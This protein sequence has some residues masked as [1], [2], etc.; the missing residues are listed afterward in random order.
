M[1]TTSSYFVMVGTKDNPLYEAEFGSM[2]RGDVAKKDDLRHLNQF[3]VHAA[4][5]MVDE[6]VWGTPAMYLKVV[7]KFNEWYVSAFVAPSGVRFMLLHDTP[8]TD[9]IR[10]FFNETHELYI[11]TLLNPFTDLNGPITSPAFDQ[12]VRAHGRKWL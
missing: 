2:A 7:D 5:D 6:L 11:R 9:G 8:N 4:L 1:A 10:N 3:V 12:K